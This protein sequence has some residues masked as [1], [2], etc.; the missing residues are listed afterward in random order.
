[1]L[2]INATQHL[3]ANVY[4]NIYKLHFLGFN[5]C[6]LKQTAEETKRYLNS[7]K[8]FINGIKKNEKD[9]TDINNTKI[10]LL[11]LLLL[12][13]FLGKKSFAALLQTTI[14]DCMSAVCLHTK[15]TASTEK[16]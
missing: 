8:Q 1:M 3:P 6:S 7:P 9:D 16:N 15:D 13:L 2:D 5:M 12:K 4:Y 14:V 10:L 11:L